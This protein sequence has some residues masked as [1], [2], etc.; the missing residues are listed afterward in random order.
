MNSKIRS[1]RYSVFSK[2]GK[3]LHKN[4][5]V[6]NCLYICEEQK[7]IKENEKNEKEKQQQKEREN[8]N[9]INYIW[10]PKATE[11]LSTESKNYFTHLTIMNKES[12]IL[13]QVILQKTK[14]K[15]KNKH[16]N[17]ISTHRKKSHLIGMV[18]ENPDELNK[19]KVNSQLVILRFFA[20]KKKILSKIV[21]VKQKVA[22]KLRSSRNYT[23]IKV[24][25][26]TKIIFHVLTVDGKELYKTVQ[27]VKHLFEKDLQKRSTLKNEEQKATNTEKKNFLSED[28]NKI[29]T[30]PMEKEYIT[31]SNLIFHVL[32]VGGSLN[33]SVKVDLSLANK[34]KN[35]HN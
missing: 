25:K 27:P 24:N 33:H 22:P 34:K 1:L 2:E 17:T 20:K 14:K 15:N 6:Q 26:N 12:Q 31:G 21:V 16:R 35:Y 9:K 28:P 4:V 30:L 29:Q 32:D 8:E 10:K 5:R 13:Y 7:Q 23:S 11:L 19:R 3:K 18:W